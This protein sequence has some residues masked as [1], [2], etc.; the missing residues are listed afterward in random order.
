MVLLKRE[1]WWGVMAH[2]YN[3]SSMVG[4]SWFEAGSRQ[5]TRDSEKLPKEKED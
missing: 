3:P 4:R 2:A 5:K 1:N